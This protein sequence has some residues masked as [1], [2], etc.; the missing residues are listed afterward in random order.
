MVQRRNN[1]H[2]LQLPWRTSP[3]RKRRAN[4]TN[5]GQSSISTLFYWYIFLELIIYAEQN[6]IKK[7][8]YNQLLVDVR[9]FAKILK[10][11]GV[12]KGDRVVIYMPMI[13][14]AAVA[15]LAC[16]RIGAVHS[17]VFGGFASDQLATRINHAKAKVV[18]G[19]YTALQLMI[20]LSRLSLR[21]IL[22]SNLRTKSSTNRWSITPLNYQSTSPVHA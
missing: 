1:E 14:E 7:I 19:I 3:A 4:S 22:A 16:A 21:L 2:V 5:M 6:S 8:T 15:M 12:Q 9:K 17:V 11:M 10:S 20:F 18:L 13:P